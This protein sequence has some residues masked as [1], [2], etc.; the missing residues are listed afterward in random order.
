M[1][2]DAIPNPINLRESL[3]NNVPPDAVLIR[4]VAC[5][6]LLCP[7]FMKIKECLSVV[8]LPLNL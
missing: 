6:F 8:E 2:V 3:I 4:F 7:F 1:F 5:V